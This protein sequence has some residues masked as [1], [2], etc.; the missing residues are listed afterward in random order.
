VN[1]EIIVALQAIS[2]TAATSAGLF[3]FGFWQDTR[4]RLFLLFAWAF[5]LLALSW[6][7]LAFVNPTDETRPYVYAIRLLAFLL[8]IVAT[9]D[10]NRPLAS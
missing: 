1:T 6:L 2:A 9:V 7:L 10:K 8:I 3:F 5:W 4:D